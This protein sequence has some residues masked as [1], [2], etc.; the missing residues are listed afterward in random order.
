L[1]EAT[2]EEDVLVPTMFCLDE[3]VHEAF[4]GRSERLPAQG[5]EP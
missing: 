4:S 5:R 1:T 2:P 3:Y